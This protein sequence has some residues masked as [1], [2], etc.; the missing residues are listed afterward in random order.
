MP[1]Q[2]TPGAGDQRGT[3]SAHV[4][5]AVALSAASYAARL[6][7]MAGLHAD[8][9]AG[10]IREGNTVRVP[11]DVEVEDL[12]LELLVVEVR[13]G[14]RR[15]RMGLGE[16]T[17]WT[18]GRVLGRIANGH[19]RLGVNGEIYMR[20][21][22]VFSGSTDLRGRLILCG[23]AWFGRLVFCRNTGGFWR[24]IIR[25]N[26]RRRVGICKPHHVIRR[27]GADFALL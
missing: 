14:E 15:W 1:E 24:L 18:C 16:M 11:P 27:L 23:N 9:A 10:G 20:W 25:R 21:R 19:G 6:V 5:L 22:L 4:R 13:Q 17:A 26:A 3:I 8:F 2:L 7:A 12:T